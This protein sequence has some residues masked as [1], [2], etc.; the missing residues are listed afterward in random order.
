M[1]DLIV[2]ANSIFA[3]SWF[4][5]QTIG[6]EPEV[7]LRLAAVTV[8]NLI[9]PIRSEMNTAF[10]RTLF[11][12]DSG[13]NDAKQREAKPPEY[14]A[15]KDIAKDVF[16]LLLGTV[17]VEVEPFEGDDLIASAVYNSDPKTNLVVASGDKD[18]MQLIEDRVAYYSFNEKCVLSETFV[19]NKFQVKKPC[20]I[21]IALAIQGDSVDNIPGVRGWGK[22]K[23]K[24]L[25]KNI[26]KDMTF[27]DCLGALENNMNAEQREQFYTSLERTLLN[28]SIKLPAPAPLIFGSDEDVA[29]LEM[30]EVLNKIREVRRLYDVA[31]GYDFN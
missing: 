5:A 29:A 10:S 13:S 23:V 31:Y 2:D 4:A 14:H 17:N 7:A 25:F 9:N 8:L 30:P 28:T 11:C 3:R 6:P 24:K 20:Q 22:D 21:A 1:N 19:C 26:T 12:W 27:Q 15:T 16:A 18:L